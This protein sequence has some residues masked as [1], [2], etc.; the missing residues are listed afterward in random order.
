MTHLERKGKEVKMPTN[1]KS[2]SLELVA[3][4]PQFTA[5][6]VTWFLPSMSD[7]ILTND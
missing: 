3:L 1:F 2:N 7:F 4:V 5:S 6:P